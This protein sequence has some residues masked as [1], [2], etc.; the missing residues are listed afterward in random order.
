[1][2][3]T[4]VLKKA[5]SSSLFL[6]ALTLL[7]FGSPAS[8]TDVPEWLRNLQRQPAKSY[9]DDVNAVILLD[10]NVT[11]VKDN[12]DILRRQRLA[13]R[14][15]RPEGRER[16]SVYGISYNVDTKV[17]YL[18]GWSI[19]AKGQE[20]ESK[21][22]DVME[23]NAT[24]F[25]VYS[26]AKEKILRVLGADVG[27]VIGFEFEELEHPMVYQDE[28]G[29]QGGEPIERSRYELHLASGWRFKADWMNH[30]EEK[31]TEENGALNWQVTD[32]PRIENE[33]RRPPAEGLAA[34]VVFTFFNDKIASKTYRDWSEF[35]TWYTQLSSNVRDASP[36]LTQKVQ[37]LAPANQPLM[38]RIKA[39]AGFA[40]HDV[41]YVAIYLKLGGW[42]P[43]NASDIFNHRYGDCKDKATVLSSMLAQIGV[44]SYYLLV[45]DTRGVVTKDRPPMLRF[46]H[47]I[48]AIALPEASYSKPMPALY[49]HPKLG[50]LLIFDPTND[51]VPFGQ[52]PYYEQD[53]YGLLVGEQGG[54]LIHMP[55]APPEAN[56]V[57]RTAKLKLLP[58][59]ALQGEI[60]ERYTGFNAML[61]RGGLQH[62]TEND[63][64]KIIERLLANSLGNFQL[65][66]F[67]LVNPN[68][69]DQD[70]VIKLTFSAAHYAKNAGSMLL[71]RPRVLGELAGRW[72]ANK[73]RHYAY[74]FP[75][76]FL[77]RDTVE[78]SLPEGFKVDEL[79][80]PARVTLPFAE[81]VSKTESSEGV[82]KYTREYKQTATE[83]SLEHTDELKKFFGQINLDE[84]NM[85]VL[86]KAN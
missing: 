60:E 51:I 75:G 45:N 17:N 64:K 5:I 71:V 61:F 40:Q 32:V 57:F 48:L 14:I 55:L 54:E 10:D 11:T 1:M 29:F 18:R 49:E 47:M 44:K 8:A 81:Y 66:K 59:G 21:S 7:T 27:T 23:R 43:H 3:V 41:R 74:E 80:D 82:L 35:G 68:D 63:R 52:I 83:V 53:N 28:W 38:E 6:F 85:A 34:G 31:P 70:L 26:D 2:E 36:A 46:N 33:P 24:S 16:F 62:E 4:S 22:S 67:E 9:A 78:I 58:D 15:L 13:W 65:D 79:P 73:P 72:D 50:H 77:A 30:K 12:G 86:K 39:L 56:G 25:E 20:Y 19:T 69:I 42:R 37:D 84:K 76:P